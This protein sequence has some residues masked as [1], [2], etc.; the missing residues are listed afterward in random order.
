[1]DFKTCCVE[2][3]EKKEVGLVGFKDHEIKKLEKKIQT[4]QNKK[5]HR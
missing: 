1:M 3:N 2:I 5:Y 4:I